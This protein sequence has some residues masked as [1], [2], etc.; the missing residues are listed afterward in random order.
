MRVSGIY[1]FNRFDP[2]DPV[3]RELGDPDKLKTLEA[4]YQFIL[5]CPDQ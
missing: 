3:F 4:T 5:T 2:H 1:T